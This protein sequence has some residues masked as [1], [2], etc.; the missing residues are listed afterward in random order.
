MDGMLDPLGWPTKWRM[1]YSDTSADL[2]LYEYKNTGPGADMSGRAGWAGLR[3][4]TDTEA[5]G[6]TVE[7]VLGYNPREFL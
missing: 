2:H 3:A 6:Y 1:E 4:L 7:K 5:A